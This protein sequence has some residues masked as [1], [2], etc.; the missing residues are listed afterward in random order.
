M[1]RAQVDCIACHQQRQHSDEMA[2]VVGQTFVAV[3]D[4]CDYC[5]GSRYDDALE[6]WT[7][8]L[9]ERLEAAEVACEQARQFMSATALDART[10]LEARRLLADAEHNVRFVKH[11]FGVHNLNY[12][13]ALLNVAL[14]NAGRV[15]DLSGAAAEADVAT[16]DPS[17][18]LE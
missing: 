7:R 14:E 16:F 6:V 4:S 12:A 9:A 1:Y 10:A 5:H 17:G 15:L 3:Q 13:M 11:G 2:G 8:R 18:A